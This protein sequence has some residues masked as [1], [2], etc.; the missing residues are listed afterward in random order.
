MSVISFLCM[1]HCFSS[2]YELPVSFFPL[3]HFPFVASY[4]S[5]LHHHKKNLMNCHSFRTSMWI[6]VC[7]CV[8]YFVRHLPFMYVHTEPCYFPCVCVHLCNS[9]SCGFA[10]LALAGPPLTSPSITVSRPTLR[11]HFATQSLTLP[12][13]AL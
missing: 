13:E 5:F 10:L 12:A 4:P 3:S 7:V 6:L 1:F 11:L 2:S 8:C 9:T